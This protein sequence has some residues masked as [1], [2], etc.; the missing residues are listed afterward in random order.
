[1]EGYGLS[2][3][4][5]ANVEAIWPRISQAATE[6][7][8]SAEKPEDSCIDLS[9]SENWL[10]RRELVNLYKEAVQAGLGDRVSSEDLAHQ[11]HKWYLIR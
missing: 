4:G 2:P 7:E 3:R 1:M 5:A 9:T 8:K 11:L 10:L 6:R